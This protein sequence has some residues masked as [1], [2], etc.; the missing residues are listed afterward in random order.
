MTDIE[1]LSRRAAA[2][3]LPAARRL[4]AALE[5]RG[6]HALRPLNWVRDHHGTEWGVV[7]QIPDGHKIF[8]HRDGRAFLGDDS[9]RTPLEAA[10]MN[11]FWQWVDTSRPI[12]A[13]FNSDGGYATIAIP[14]LRIPTDDSPSA[15]RTE[16]ARTYT[17]GSPL[18]GVL[19]LA[20]ALGVTVRFVS[21][22][23]ARTYRILEE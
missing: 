12:L 16:P 14:V 8:V 10:D 19:W 3:D 20:A 15:P 22:G 4:V 18:M 13:E 9:G 5:S 1:R 23:I 17:T 11:G 2:G 7:R 6:R 21:D